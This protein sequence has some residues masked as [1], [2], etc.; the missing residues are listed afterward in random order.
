MVVTKLLVEGIQL[1]S[2]HQSTDMIRTG[3]FGAS[4]QVVSGSQIRERQTHKILSDICALHE[5]VQSIKHLF[6]LKIHFLKRL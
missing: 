4:T 6:L 2:A 3:L 5:Y 1:T